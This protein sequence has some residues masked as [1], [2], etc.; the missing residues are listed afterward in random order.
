[1]ATRN[2][3]A[4]A[5]S[6][7]G[8]IPRALRDLLLLAALLAAGSAQ[9]ECQG[10]V[11]HAHRGSAAA[12]E[13]SLAA[14]RLAFEGEWDGAEIDIQQLRDRQWVLH[15]DAQLGRT[16]S[17]QGRSVRD[18]DSATWREVRLKDRQGK[19]GAEP[20][21][22]LSDVLGSV[23]EREDKVLNVEI[24]QFNGSCDAAQQAVA[25]LHRG[26]PAGRWFLTAIDR[27]QLQCARKADPHGY[28]GQIA[29]DAQALARENGARTLARSV[30][31][32]VLDTAWLR[33]L[34]QDVGSPVGVH[35]DI[36]TLAANP[37]LLADAKALQLPVFSY[38]LGSDRE[39]AE[40]LKAYASRSGLWPS[41]A[42]ID[43]APSAFCSLLGKP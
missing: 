13:N 21:P 24:K 30:N 33:R 14:V 11:L 37:G 17:L 41:G 40:A 42:I 6:S 8:H 32:P 31:A 3:P 27:R 7:S 19:V 39:H 10:M 23:A 34:Q 18:L 43:G 2:H 35:V 25:V 36:N 29:L 26:Q 20:A 1:M 15:H 22:F 5:D 16:T 38:H 12:P 9:A 4:R 28:L